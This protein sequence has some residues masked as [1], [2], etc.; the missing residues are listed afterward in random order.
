MGLLSRAGLFVGRRSALWD[1]SAAKLARQMERQGHA[2]E[3]IWNATG[4]FRGV[5]RRWRQMADNATL[6][7]AYP[8]MKVRIVDKPRSTPNAHTIDTVFG[9]R[10]TYDSR[11]QDADK[12]LAHEIQHLIQGREGFERGGNDVTGWLAAR[13]SGQRGRGL[14]G[15]E[16]YRRLRGEVEA[17]QVEDLLRMTPTQRRA[18]YPMAAQEFGPDF[19]LSN[20]SANATLAAL[21]A[22][23][24]GLGGY[25]LW[26]WIAR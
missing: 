5:D 7:E 6:A 26:N 22:G 13:L 2:P 9:K 8:S 4:T 16:A 14:S 21:S 19:Q 10:I 11:W 20:R 18:T 24:A 3:A 15:D 1:Q 17:R 25:S 12:S 23:S